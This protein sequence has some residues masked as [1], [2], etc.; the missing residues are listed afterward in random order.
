MF[1]GSVLCCLFLADMYGRNLQGSLLLRAITAGPLPCLCKADSPY[2]TY[3]FFLKRRAV[4]HQC[5]LFPLSVAAGLLNKTP[6]HGLAWVLLFSAVRDGFCLN[7]LAAQHQQNVITLYINGPTAYKS[8]GMTMPLRMLTSFCSLLCSGNARR[9]P[10]PA[11]PSHPS[12]G[13]DRA[14]SRCCIWDG[15]STATIVQ[16]HRNK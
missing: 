4:S 11:L 5:P 13:R 6:F 3:S 7:I 12:A 10:S 14:L 1:F 9:V 16:A 2:A 15:I 8:T